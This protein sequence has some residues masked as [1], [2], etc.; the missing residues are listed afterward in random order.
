MVLH[1]PNNW[2]W[3]DKNCISW[4]RDY[5]KEN[6]VGISAESEANS[7]AVSE[8]KSVEGDVEVCQRKGKVISLFDVAINLNYQGKSGETD[9]KGTIN[10]PEVSYDNDE[11]DYQFS[12][13]V[14]PDNNE[15]AQI[16]SLVRTKLVPQLRTALFKFGPDL[17]NTH[18]GA[19]QHSGNEPL[20]WSL[21]ERAKANAAS[22]AAVDS[23]KEQK[24]KIFGVGVVST[25]SIT[26]KPSFNASP[27]QLYQ[28][29]TR[30]DMVS[31]WSHSKVD[32]EPAAGGKFALFGGNV[33]GEFTEIV[34]NKSIKMKWRLKDWSD[35]H[36][37]QLSFQFLPQDSETIMETKWTGVP[38]DQRQKVETNFEN[39]YVKPIKA[40]FGFGLL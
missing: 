34:E 1:N 16:K 25:T 18:G 4:S 20:H 38:V 29:L 30:P 12:I 14:D 6:L 27:D 39:Y 10:I 19:I 33:S 24:P 2:H 36:Y 5:F 40:T 23:S 35:N 22:K 28:A 8:V 17:S 9:V 26:L 13:T 7:V 3:V 11:D 37:A 21:T 15:T 32:F 31:A